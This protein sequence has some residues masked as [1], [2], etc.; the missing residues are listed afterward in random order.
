MTSG[1]DLSF[2]TPHRRAQPG[3]LDVEFA[4]RADE[5]SDCRV[6]DGDPS[7]ESGDRLRDV[8]EPVVAAGERD[9]AVCDRARQT[10][11]RVIEA[12]RQRPMIAKPITLSG[13]G[14]PPVSELRLG[15]RE[16]RVVGRTARVAAGDACRAAMRRA[17]MASE[18]GHR[19]R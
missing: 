15:P 17:G 5:S 11:V 2:E 12:A 16:P 8:G 6:A 3:N 7:S 9:D 19:E 13:G 14:E 18:S 4:S 10:P 1:S